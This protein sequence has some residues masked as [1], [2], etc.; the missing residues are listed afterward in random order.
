MAIQVYMTN[1]NNNNNNKIFQ[2]RSTK[3][4]LDI[5]LYYTFAPPCFFGSIECGF[6][7]HLLMPR[8][9]CQYITCMQGGFIRAAY[10]GIKF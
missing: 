6:M 1:N 8:L 3:N 10:L 9:G 5:Q 4:I 7:P 2:L